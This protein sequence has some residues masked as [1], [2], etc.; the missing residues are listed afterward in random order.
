MRAQT[1]FRIQ[2]ENVDKSSRTAE[3]SDVYV[4]GEVLQK[5]VEHLKDFKNTKQE[6]FPIANYWKLE[7]L[8]FTPF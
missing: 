7:N 3:A 4:R 6:S 1:Y 5:K 2:S 8:A